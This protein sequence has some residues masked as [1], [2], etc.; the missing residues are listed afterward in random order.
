MSQSHGAALWR[1]PVGSGAVPDAVPVFF[2]ASGSDVVPSLIGPTQFQFIDV[3]L[4]GDYTLLN[5][6]PV[7]L[8]NDGSGNAV[9][10]NSGPAAFVLADG[11]A[12]D[13]EVTNDLTRAPIADLL[14]D[15]GGDLWLVRRSCPRLDAVQVRGDVIFY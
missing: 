13:I 2:V 1:E 4:D 9:P 6:S 14:Y 3:A 15:P 5:L 7:Y 12:G 10:S 11:F 8:I